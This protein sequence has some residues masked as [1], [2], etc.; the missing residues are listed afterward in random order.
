MSQQFTQNCTKKTFTAGEALTQFDLVYLSAA[1]TV[2]QNDLTNRPI[3]VAQ[4]AAASGAP[5]EVALLTPG[6][7]YK[8]RAVEA[9]AAG[10]TLYTEAGG[11]VQDTAQATSHPIMIALE[12][13]TAEDDI[14]EATPIV[15]G[16][17]AAS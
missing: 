10:A 5:V 17:P 1:G 16:G 3:G 9:L 7:T 13:A 2:S 4:T 15:Y 11:E 6:C 14:I 8:V 12:A